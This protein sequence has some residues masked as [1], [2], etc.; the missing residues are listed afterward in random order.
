VRDWSENDASEEKRA[1]TIMCRKGFQPKVYVSLIKDREISRLALETVQ[2]PEAGVTMSPSYG[3]CSGRRRIHGIRG[4]STEG[5]ES[6]WQR[7][8]VGAS[9]SFMLNFLVDASARFNPVPRHT[10][11]L[12]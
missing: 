1:T 10:T 4:K 7:L 2:T 11:N 6:C 3:Y 9:C 12:V 8:L 5:S